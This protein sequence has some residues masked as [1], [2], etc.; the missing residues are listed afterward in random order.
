MLLDFI[1]VLLYVIKISS[2]EKFFFLFTSTL[3]FMFLSSLFRGSRFSFC[4]I[5]LLF[6]LPSRRKLIS[7]F[8]IA[9]VSW[10]H[11]TFPKSLRTQSLLF[12]SFN[13]SQKYSFSATSSFQFSASLA[14][15]CLVDVSYDC[16]KGLVTPPSIF[17]NSCLLFSSKVVRVFF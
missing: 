16:M 17:F 6:L 14:V 11:D 1:K 5:M 2:K 15:K 13:S 12:R 9:V 3:H 4:I 10:L 7:G 8:S